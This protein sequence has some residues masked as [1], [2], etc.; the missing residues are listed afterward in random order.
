MA[1]AQYH[2]LPPMAG[3]VVWHV[4]YNLHILVVDIGFTLK[5]F[6][7]YPTIIIF[8]ATDSNLNASFLA[9]WLLSQ[10]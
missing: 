9:M 10:L 7:S 5:T 4:W 1:L 3:H 6:P 2:A 8:H